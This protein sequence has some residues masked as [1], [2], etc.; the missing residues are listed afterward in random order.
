M[1][2]DANESAMEN[3][4][5]GISLLDLNADLGEKRTSF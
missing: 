4:A 5:K 2:V 3:A 1:E